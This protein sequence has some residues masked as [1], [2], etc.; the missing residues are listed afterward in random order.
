MALDRYSLF[1]ASFTHAGGTMDL[2]QLEMQGLNTGSSIRTIRPGGALAPA[3]HILSYANPRFRFRTA[4]LFTVLTAMGSN[5]F[6]YCSG[7]HVARWQ[8]RSPGGTFATSTAHLT[9]A[10]SKGFLHV[11]SID[12]SI[13][14]TEGAVM[15]LEYIPLSTNG[16]NP[17]TDTTSVN[18]ASAP[19]PAFVSQYF[20]GGVWNASTQVTSLSRAS[21]RPGVNFIMRRADSGVFCL[22]GASSIGSYSPQISL[23]FMDVALPY[24]MGSQF[25]SIVGAAIKG[26]LQRG[27]TAANGRIAAATSGHAKVSCTDASWGADD[28]TV[29][30]EDD[31]SVTV[32]VY[33][34][35]ALT[36][37]LGV[38]L[39]A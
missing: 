6:L 18:F 39:G 34:T 30:G 9:Q 22:D 33:P 20:L 8:K 14:A 5:M 29:Q 7:G 32:A 19:A 16:L 4:D 36:P 1:S 35:S 23:N 17:I 13:D 27:T 38:A 10:T 21:F 15:E 26:Y 12:A 3:A 2:T 11:V 28:M 37:A 24:S 31:G 25:L